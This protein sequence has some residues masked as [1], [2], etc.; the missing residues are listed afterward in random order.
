MPCPALET[1]Y[2]FYYNIN[3]DPVVWS[4]G[5][6]MKNKLGFTLLELLVVV[7]IIGILAAIALPQYRKAVI[8]ARF[9]EVD[10]VV[11]AAKKNI[12]MYFYVHDWPRGDDEV[13]FTGAFNA[14]SIDLPGNCESPTEC[15]TK[16]ANYYV[17]CDQSKCVIDMSFKFLETGTELML[18]MLQGRD[19][20][21][22]ESGSALTREICQ[23]LQERNYPGT[24]DAVSQCNEF[25]ISLREYSME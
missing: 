15:E 22:G 11:N 4:R 19:T 14:N 13:F 24:A 25:G 2:V 12:Q 1:P 5:N 3:I 17:E 10:T 9:A 23:W 7:L 6:I 21:F 20:W 16:L 18:V 8:R